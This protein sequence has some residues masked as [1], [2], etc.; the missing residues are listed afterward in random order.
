M[1]I[2]TRDG[3]ALDVIDA[4]VV[5]F[6]PK[7]RTPL[8]DWRDRVDYHV[9]R[10]VEF[11]ARELTGQSELRATVVAEP[12]CSA[13]TSDEL[14]LGD[15]TFT[16][17]QT[18]GEV[19][20][21]L[22]FARARVGFPVL[23]VLSDINWHELDDFWRVRMTDEGPVFDGV[24]V[25]GCHVPGS[26]AGGSRATYVPERGVGLALVSADGWRVPYRGSDCVV[27]HEGIGHAIG[28]PHPEQ[29]DGSV[30]SHAQ[31][32]GE[33]RESWLAGADKRAL[34]WTPSSPPVIATL[35]ARVE[36]AVPRPGESI[37]LHC[38]W[39][40]GAR[41][42]SGTVAW[43]CDLRGPWTTHPLAAGAPLL[44]VPLPSFATPSPVSY[45][46]AAQLVDGRDVDA[47]GYFQVRVAPDEA[48]LP[49]EPPALAPAL[50]GD[51][52]RVIATRR[53]GASDL[54]IACPA[55]ALRAPGEWFVVDRP[56]AVAWIVDGPS[57]RVLCDGRIVEQTLAAGE[58]AAVPDHFVLVE[59]RATSSIERD[60]MKNPAMLAR[61]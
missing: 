11:H 29:A 15:P 14:R 39:P 20:R 58:P 21:T 6:V 9:R 12:V 41:I 2:A 47:W 25:G 38:S 54:V 10:L 31:Y 59:L 26:P 33:L 50:P 55:Y 45:R 34:G 13:L 35:R 53:A 49:P 17:M 27:Y 56:T 37:A 7:G 24:V 23:I 51:V 61:T 42:A 36:P 32:R 18:I 3:W 16:F 19:E 52:V 4:T 43:Q 8:V 40:A 1:A 30:M 5:Y 57:V 60:R 48:P 46:I 22:G 28:L 44:A